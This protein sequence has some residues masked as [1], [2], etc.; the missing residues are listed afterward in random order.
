MNEEEKRLFDMAAE[1][2][3]NGNKLWDCGIIG[4]NHY[5]THA[6][7][8]EETAFFSTFGTRDDIQRRRFSERGKLDVVFFLLENGVEVFCLVDSGVKK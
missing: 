1:L 7:H 6:I 5:P 2:V 4:I 8:M 3:K